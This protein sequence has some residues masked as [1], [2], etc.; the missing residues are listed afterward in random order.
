[1]KH[2]KFMNIERLKEG[3]ADGFEVGDYVVI[4]EKIGELEKC[5]SLLKI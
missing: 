4:Q 3:Y 2:K 5:L 1:M